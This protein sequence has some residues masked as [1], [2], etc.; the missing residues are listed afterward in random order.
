VA[1]VKPPAY[2]SQSPLQ[3]VGLG[4]PYAEELRDHIARSSFDTA[5]PACSEDFGLDPLGRERAVPLPSFEPSS[6]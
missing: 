6:S 2:R 5:P 1:E 3:R 4:H